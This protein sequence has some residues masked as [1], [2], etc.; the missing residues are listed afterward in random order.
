MRTWTS[1]WQAVLQAFQPSPP[2]MHAFLQKETSL[3]VVYSRTQNTPLF[4]KVKLITPVIRMPSTAQRVLKGKNLLCLIQSLCIT[5][6]EKKKPVCQ[7]LPWLCSIRVH[8]AGFIFT[9]QFLCC[10]DFTNLQSIN[11]LSKQYT[12]K[13][14]SRGNFS[15]ASFSSFCFSGESSGDPPTWDV[16]RRKNSWHSWGLALNHIIRC[17]Y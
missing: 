8:R 17:R 4:G 2:R 10:Y 12:S 1:L 7:L 9:W 3:C 5:G 16:T 14:R 6:G 11:H 15:K 13:L